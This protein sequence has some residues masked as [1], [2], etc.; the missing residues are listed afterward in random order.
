MFPMGVNERLSVER[1]MSVPL[2][3]LPDDI[4]HVRNTLPLV[5][6]AVKLSNTGLCC[7]YRQLLSKRKLSS[8]KNLTDAGSCFTIHGKR[9]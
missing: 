8:E 5:C 4:T 6:V 7:A 3:V 1:S 2:Q 9:S